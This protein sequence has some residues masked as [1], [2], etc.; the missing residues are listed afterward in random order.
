MGEAQVEAF[1]DER[2]KVT[3]ASIPLTQGN[4]GSG[5]ERPGP[6]KKKGAFRALQHRN[7]RI[8]WT[9]QMI[10]LIGTW[11]QNLAQGW[12]I[13][14]LVDPV[15][16]AL[17]HHGVSASAA[18]AQGQHSAAVEAAANFYSGWINFA[19]GLPIFILTLFAGVLADR[20]S[21][22]HLLLVTQSVLIACAIS[23]GLLCEFGL[24]QIWHVMLIAVIA[25]IASAFDMPT[26]QSFVVE[27]VSREI[28]P[29][30]SPSIPASSM[31]HVRSVLRWRD[32]CWQPT[33]ALELRL[34]VMGF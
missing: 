19:G 1:V 11:M 34:S 16:I 10:S 25:G 12:L 32:C 26:R 31:Q 30:P 3:P 6:A 20:V 15:A 13:V 21:K 33:S 18:G 2:R 27:M 17:L 23:L 8:F 9:G 5:P 14:L 22:R 28:C 24:V 7:F 29:V 4:L